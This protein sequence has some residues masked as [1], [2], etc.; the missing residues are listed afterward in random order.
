[1]AAE[2]L[3]STGRRGRSSDR[4][5]VLQREVL[6]GAAPGFRHVPRDHLETNAGSVPGLEECLLDL[7]TLSPRPAIK[8]KQGHEVMPGLT[9]LCTNENPSRSERTVDGA[10]AEEQVAIPAPAFRGHWP[11][12]TAGLET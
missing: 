6:G 9:L 3:G 12:G 7:G 11:P 2:S 8:H 1:M 10:G 5:E 4:G